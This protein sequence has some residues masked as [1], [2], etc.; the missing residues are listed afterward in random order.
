M[1]ADAASAHRLALSPPVAPTRPPLVP[2][3][4]L[5]AA[6]ARPSPL[7]AVVALGLLGVGSLPSLVLAWI[8]WG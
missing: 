1:T 6:R 7:E 4:A 2:T 5:A 8:A 3:R